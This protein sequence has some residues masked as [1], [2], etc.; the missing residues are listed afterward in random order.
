[1]DSSN[2]W[3]PRFRPHRTESRQLVPNLI[4]DAALE[5]NSF[6]LEMCRCRICRVAKPEDLQSFAAEVCPCEICRANTDKNLSWRPT[7]LSNAA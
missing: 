1:M 5:C 4:A 2:S 3:D 6:V 7:N